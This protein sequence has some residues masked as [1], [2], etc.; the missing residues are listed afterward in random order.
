ML[1]I[2]Q[3]FNEYDAFHVVYLRGN[4]TDKFSKDLSLPFNTN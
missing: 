4:I 1:Y 2:A 3:S